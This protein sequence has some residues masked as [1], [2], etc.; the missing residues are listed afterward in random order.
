MNAKKVNM[1]FRSKLVREREREREQL[2]SPTDM[3]R[4]D[5]KIDH[6]QMMTELW[7]CTQTIL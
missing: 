3:S 2:L 4:K 1:D 6:K 7:H 5:L